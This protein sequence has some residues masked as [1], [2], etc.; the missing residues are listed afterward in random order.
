MRSRFLFIFL[1]LSHRLGKGYGYRPLDTTCGCHC[2]DASFVD[3]C[4]DATF[5]Y[6]RVIQTSKV[7]SI[8]YKKLNNDRQYAI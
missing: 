4:Y 6:V 2:L 8:S 7:Y 1:C 5:I 3:R